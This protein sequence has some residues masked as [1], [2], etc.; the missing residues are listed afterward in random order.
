MSGLPDKIQKRVLRQALTKVGDLFVNAAKANLSDH[1]RTHNLADHVIQIVRVGATSASVR[2]GPEDAIMADRGLTKHPDEQFQ[3]AHANAGIYG[4]F[5]ELGFR[6]HMYP[7][8]RPAFK[9]TVEQATQ[10]FGEAVK[11]GVEENS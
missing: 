9:A 3:T 11:T 4:R 1:T 7:W 2:V 6:G 10:V 8:L 5:L